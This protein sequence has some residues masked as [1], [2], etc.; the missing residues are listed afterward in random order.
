VMGIKEREFRPLPDNFSLEELIPKDNF[1][2]R[3]ERRL[4]LSFVRELVAD[5]YAAVGRHSVDPVVFFRLQL[6]MF[7]E[8]IR[9]E[10]ELMKMAS[11][12]L[13]VRWYLG[14]DLHEPLPDHSS[15]TRIRERYGLETFRGFFERIVEICVEAGLVRGEELFFDSTKVKANADIDSLA[16][17]FL[18]ETHLNGLFEG[19]SIPEGSEVRPSVGTGLDALPTSD[20][21][22]LSAANV[23]KSDWISRVGKQDRSFSSGP[24]KRTSDL[25]VSRTDPDATPML[26]GEG[27]AKLGYQTHY[28]VDGGKARIILT[29]LVTPSEVSE[30]RPMLDLLWRSCFRW[31]IWPH[32]VTGDGKYGTAENVAAVEQA[33]VRAFVSLHRSGGRPNI[34]GREDFTYDPKEDVYVCPAGELLRPLGKKKNEEEREEKVT[35]YRAMASSCKTCQLRSRCTSDKLGRNL[36]RGPFEGYLDRVRSYAGTHSYE[37]ALRKRKVWIEPLFGEAKD[38]HGM[39]IFRLRRLEKVNIEAL[40][41]ASGQNVKRLL[42]F[43]GHR[44]KK[45]AQTTALRPPATTSDETSC[46]WKHVARRCRFSTRAFFNTLGRFWY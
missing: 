18:V 38:W 9:S 35:T 45:L 34:F 46:V 43:G 31:Q 36:R 41:I 40:L 15:L 17:R 44:P 23:G 12:R 5:R 42:I 24:R 28:V 14:Y 22:R 6:V 10:R 33:N 26:I 27:E 7:F 4:D 3:L 2:R 19:S 13:S 20:D 32:H 30:N 8:G 25:R 16:S 1:Y 37:K 39:R 11:D 21:E 29:A